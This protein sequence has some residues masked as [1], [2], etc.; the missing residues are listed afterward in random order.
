MK[1]RM[2]LI[3]ALTASLLLTLVVFS[4]AQG[5][6]GRKPVA[7]TGVIPLG[8][9]QLLRLTV[10]AG[11]VNGDGSVVQFRQVGYMQASCNGGVCKHTVV[12]QSTSAPV[13]L[14]LGEAAS[15][16]ILSNSFGVR[17]MVL[18]N[19]Q[20]VRVNA[21]IVDATTGNIIGVLMPL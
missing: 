10:A 15:I 16:D 4:I 11:D 6:T 14:M 9:N 3:L 19:N 2:T 7:D 12:S 1:R 5:Q 13:T 18:S 20:N 8:P 21:M 17:A